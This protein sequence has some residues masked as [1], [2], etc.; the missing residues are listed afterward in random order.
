MSTVV[1]LKKNVNG[2]ENL[3][4]GVRSL[5][6]MTSTQVLSV[7]ITIGS[8]SIALSRLL[9]LGVA[10]SF[11]QYQNALLHIALAWDCLAAY[12]KLGNPIQNRIVRNCRP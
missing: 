2:E 12:G 3:P 8:A 10:F 11:S 4:H 6:V 7:K 1:S 5:V 9:G